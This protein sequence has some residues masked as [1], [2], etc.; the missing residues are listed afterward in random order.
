MGRPP[1][2]TDDRDLPGLDDG[3]AQERRRLPFLLGTDLADMPK[4]KK[5]KT[6]AGMNFSQAVYPHPELLRRGQERAAGACSRIVSLS[7]FRV[8]SPSRVSMGGNFEPGA[9]SRVR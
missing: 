1:D 6:R 8:S 2:R 5:L 4:T 9:G 3:H 7:R